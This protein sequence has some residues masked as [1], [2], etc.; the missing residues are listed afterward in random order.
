MYKLIFRPWP[1]ASYPVLSLIT[2]NL[3]PIPRD[4]FLGTRIFI[5]SLNCLKAVALGKSSENKFSGFALS[6]INSEH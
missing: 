2:R 1:C 4:Y 6:E 5:R 3:K